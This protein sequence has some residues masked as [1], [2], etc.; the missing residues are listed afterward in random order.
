MR[1]LVWASPPAWQSSGTHTCTHLGIAYYCAGACVCPLR[2]RAPLPPSPD[3]FAPP[4]LCRPLLLPRR[5][6]SLGFL[7]SIRRVLPFRSQERH[8]IMQIAVNLIRGATRGRCRREEAT[9][10]RAAVH[11]PASHAVMVAILSPTADGTSLHT[12]RRRK[13]RCSTHTHTH[14]HTHIHTS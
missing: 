13:P 11:L 2:R 1:Q 5:P 14:T 10:R 6:I 9:H 12:L 7:P 4:S 8:P 3:R